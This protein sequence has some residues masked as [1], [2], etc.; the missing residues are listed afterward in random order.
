MSEPRDEGLS[1][2]AGEIEQAVDEQRLITAENRAIAEAWLNKGKPAVT[3]LFIE[4]MLIVDD[5]PKKDEVLAA[6]YNGRKYSYQPLNRGTA[7]TLQHID[8]LIQRSPL[9]DT[10]AYTE[11][12]LLTNYCEFKGSFRNRHYF[13]PDFLTDPAAEDMRV[14]RGLGALHSSVTIGLGDGH[15]DGFRSAD[16]VQALRISGAIDPEVSNAL[17][18]M[19][20]SGKYNEEVFL[21]KI[22]EIGRLTSR[23][24]AETQAVDRR[25]TDS[26][27]ISARI[28]KAIMKKTE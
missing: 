25:R 23:I 5:M 2:F 8:Q 4:A 10:G 24:A 1:A 20:E 13:P 21:A 6:G 15:L 27:S 7:S 17:K 16:I 11:A 9:H 18:A 19:R 26:N 3:A 22:L 12:K 28:L 14:E